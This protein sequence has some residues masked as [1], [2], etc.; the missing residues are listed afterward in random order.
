MVVFVTEAENCCDCE[1]WI[2]DV[3][4]ATETNTTGFTV[5]VALVLLVVSAA[6]V[7]VTVTD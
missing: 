3:P 2:E 5:T 6:L 4:G 7:A 1:G